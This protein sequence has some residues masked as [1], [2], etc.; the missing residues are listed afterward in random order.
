[1]ADDKEYLENCGGTMSKSEIPS[2]CVTGSDNRLPLIVVPHIQNPQIENPLLDTFIRLV[3]EGFASSPDF[4]IY[5]LTNTPRTEDLIV[6][7]VIAANGIESQFV[8][9]FEATVWLPNSGGTVRFF[10]QLMLIAD[11]NHAKS[12]ASELVAKTHSML[13]ARGFG[14]ILG[15]ASSLIN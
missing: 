4:R 6:V 15:A 10:G 3:Q 5:A 12:G 13:A 2:Q 7:N 1:M 11:R 8:V 9:F 14:P